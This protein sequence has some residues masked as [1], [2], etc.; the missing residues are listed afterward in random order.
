MR[1]FESGDK[2]GR[3][4]SSSHLLTRRASALYAQYSPSG[5]A[6][7]AKSA[8]DLDT[9][10]RDLDSLKCSVPLCFGRPHCSDTEGSERECEHS[11]FPATNLGTP[12]FLFRT[13]PTRRD[14]AHPSSGLAQSCSVLL[15]L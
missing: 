6:S 4:F 7:D 15:T 10:M 11:L 5:F 9:T 8:N 13:A 1:I 2:L 12:N 14:V 3:T